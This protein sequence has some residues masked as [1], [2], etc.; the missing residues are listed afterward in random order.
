VPLGQGQ[1]FDRYLVESLLG[2]G[3][4]GEVYSAVDARLHRRVALKV[5][6][7]DR[8]A[9]APR[10]LREARA[11][12]ALSHPNVVAVYDLGEAEGR[13]FI[14]M[15][16]VDGKLLSAFIGNPDVSTGQKLAWLLDVARGLNAAHKAGLI[17][18]DVKP[19]NI[20]VSN[21]GALKILDFGLAKR[22][23]PGPVPMASEGAMH[24]AVG[25][26]VGTPRYMAPE[27]LAGLPLD[28]RADQYGW[29]LLAYELLAN[30]N[31][32]DRG[33]APPK[34]LSELV[35]GFPF[36]LAVATARTLALDPTDRF[37]SMEELL[38][39]VEAV[40]V[41]LDAEGRISLTDPT[42]PTA[43]APD[44]TSGPPAVPLAESQP[45]APDEATRV[46]KPRFQTPVNPLVPP[47]AL[48]A[49]QLSAGTPAPPP[50]L[51]A[52]SLSPQW[53]GPSPQPARVDVVAH[54]AAPPIGSPPPAPNAVTPQS[55][56]ISTEGKRP[57]SATWVLP[58]LI[59][60]G[61]GLLILIAAAVFG[62]YSV[63]RS[64]TSPAG[65]SGGSASLA[66]IPPSAPLSTGAPS[67]TQAAETPSA[68]KSAT[69]AATIVPAPTSTFKPRPSSSKASGPSTSKTQTLGF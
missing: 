15:E 8:A 25:R 48:A 61:L 9:D 45:P 24:T 29:G 49:T 64:Q 12:A 13:T 52:T 14:A 59:A 27:Q 58:V 63:S 68:A 66:P 10:F 51:S 30:H 37:P 62:A 1:T 31:P 26:V 33:M 40:E 69:G 34:L 42:A 56:A 32:Q 44:R 6:R 17:H 65:A 4:W 11:A 16:L 47:R 22:T 53:G 20:M 38:K 23:A 54:A 50:G 57:K 21:D 28:A 2:Q 55:V 18:R 60:S 43:R 41:P 46:E 19:Q 7:E 67:A 5:L 36:E 35:P 3:G 39:A